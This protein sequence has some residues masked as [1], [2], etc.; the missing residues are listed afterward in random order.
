VPELDAEVGTGEG[1]LVGAIGGAIVDVE[2][3]GESAF[4]ERLLEA[5]LERGDLL[6]R[7]PRGVGTS[8][9]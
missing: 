6:A 1:E 7:V 8:L 5:V 2:R 9:E 4:E 3:V